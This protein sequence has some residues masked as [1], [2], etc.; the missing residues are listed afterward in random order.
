M[1]T[2]TRNAPERI[3]WPTIVVVVVV[4][5]AHL[6]LLAWHRSLPAPVFV[7]LLAVLG[8]WYMSV[9][10]ETLH[11]HPTPWPA[12][13]TA[14]AWVPLSLWLPFRVYRDS[15][16]LHHEAE[17][18]MPGIDP[19]SFYVSADDWAEAGP[20]R[21]VVLRINRTFLGRLVV[22]PWL[23]IPATVVSGL[24][25]ARTDRTLRRTWLVHVPTATVVGWIVFGVFGVP[26][27]QYLVGYVWGGVAVAYIRS[28]AEHLPVPEPATRCAMVRSNP[29]MSL[30][31]MNVN[32]HYTHHTLPGV[33][34]YRLPALS[35]E[36]GAEA[37]AAEGAGAYRGYWQ[38]FR[39]YAVRPFGQPQHPFAEATPT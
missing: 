2:R 23:G 10:H 14:L 31:F 11:G 34:W 33:A 32:L 5:A 29:V 27:W 12:V 18:T 21:R 7:V 30:L 26:V 37:I 8:G 28:F 3:E 36:L 6:A 17:L 4:W 15:H 16:L 39:R 1:G 25:Q 24:R 19:E 13:N 9:Q 35:R 22:G 20:L 38:I